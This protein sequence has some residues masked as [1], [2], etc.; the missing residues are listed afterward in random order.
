MIKRI[1]LAGTALMMTAAVANAQKYA[2]IDTKY[3]LSKIK[4]YTD[5]DKKLEQLSTSWQ[6]EIDDKQTALDLMY[7]N[8]EAEQ[9]M[10]S[11]EL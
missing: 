4:D 6:K 3:I 2:V 11:D 1:L 8:Y 7:K 9:Y 5:A 10:L